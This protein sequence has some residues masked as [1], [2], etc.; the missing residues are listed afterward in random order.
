VL[1]RPLEVTVLLLLPVAAL[2]RL[3]LQHHLLS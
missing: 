3:G 2:V 1:L